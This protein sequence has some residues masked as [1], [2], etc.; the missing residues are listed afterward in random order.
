MYMLHIPM[1]EELHFAPNQRITNTTAKTKLASSGTAPAYQGDYDAI[2]SMHN[3]AL[4]VWTDF[5]AG[6]YGSYVGFFPDYAMLVSPC[7]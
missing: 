1:M 4:L 6:N 5:R 7:Y 3:Q 2:T